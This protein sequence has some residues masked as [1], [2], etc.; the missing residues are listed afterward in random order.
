MRPPFFRVPRLLPHICPPASA[1]KVYYAHLL[2]LKKK[3]ESSKLSVN[4]ISNGMSYWHISWHWH[5][6]SLLLGFRRYSGDDKIKRF[7]VFGIDILYFLMMGMCLI[8]RTL[9]SSS[10]RIS[11][12]TIPLV[13]DFSAKCSFICNESVFLRL[14]LTG[15]MNLSMSTRLCFNY[16]LNCHPDSVL[17]SSF[18][19]E[20]G[21][22][23]G[24]MAIFGLHS[25]VTR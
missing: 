21:C 2:L 8:Q 16:V 7:C 1:M 25:D 12:D 20:S 5:S 22:V 23:L 14:R 13:T 17:L 3:G 4:G 9:F 10:P 18:S 15:F 24:S 11:F 19:T 6:F